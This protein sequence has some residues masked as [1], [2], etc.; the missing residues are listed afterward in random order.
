MHTYNS[1]YVQYV[2]PSSM[3]AFVQ[4]VC[5]MC[6]NMCVKLWVEC[7]QNVCGMSAEC[8]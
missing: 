5:G 8:V 6:V 7:V 4:N 2:C 3:G 1:H